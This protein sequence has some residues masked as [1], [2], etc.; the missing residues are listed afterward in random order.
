MEAMSTHPD[1]HPPLFNSP[2]ETGLRALIILEAFHPRPCDLTEMTWFDHLVVH[3]A[4]LDGLHDTPAPESLHPDLPARTGELLVRRSLVE[5]SL[6][7]MQQVHL[8]DAVPSNEGIHF[9][10]SDEAPSFLD[11]LQA[12][13]TRDLKHRARWIAERFAGRPSEEI[14]ALVAARIGRWTAEF[15]APEAAGTA[16]DNRP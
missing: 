6:R 3:T 1:S 11:L 10:A 5:E 15:H 2:L 4:D 14:G 9:V 13:Y 8:V 12:P 7:L 16:R